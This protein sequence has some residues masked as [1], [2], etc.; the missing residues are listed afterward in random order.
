MLYLD[1]VEFGKGN[2]DSEDEGG[3]FHESCSPSC[4]PGV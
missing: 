3:M 2:G 1:P 4:T